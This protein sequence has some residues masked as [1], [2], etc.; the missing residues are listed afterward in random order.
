MLELDVHKEY[1][2]WRS[3]M[4]RCN[5]PNHYQY[6]YYGRKGI[7]VAPEWHDFD[8]FLE[9][10]GEVDHDEF[11]VRRNA[12]NDYSKDNCK[13]V[14]FIEL[15]KLKILTKQYRNNEYDIALLGW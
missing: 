12:A 14:T 15:N 10:M 7:K 4:N 2:A 6:R 11:L 13:W 5:D 1:Q 8:V 3:M 9:D